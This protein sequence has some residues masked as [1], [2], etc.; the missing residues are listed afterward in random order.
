MDY[1]AEILPERVAEAMRRNKITQA[2]QGAVSK[3][4]AIVAV[5]VAAAGLVLT[6]TQLIPWGH[7]GL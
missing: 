6:I 3:N 2:Q 5:V 4:A 1:S 7:G